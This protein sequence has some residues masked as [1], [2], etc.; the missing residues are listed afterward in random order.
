[1]SS[2]VDRLPTLLAHWYATQS[3]IR[4]LWAIDERDS[5]ISVFVTL[6]PTFDGDDA[7]PIWL[8]KCSDWA[9]ELRVLTDCEVSLKL[10]ASGAFEHARLDTTAATI[11]ELNWRDP[12]I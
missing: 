6:E 3:S 10:I 7:L 9:D 11:T 2:S 5:G 4:R 1:M 8:A 12:W